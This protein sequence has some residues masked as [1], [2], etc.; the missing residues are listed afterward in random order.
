[1]KL[2]FFEN[3]IRHFLKH[4][5]NMLT[6][7]VANPI[8]LQKIYDL[9]EEA[10]SGDQKALDNLHKYNNVNVR[11]AGYQAPFITLPKPHQEKYVERSILS[12]N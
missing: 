2:A 10:R 7:T 6:V 4:K 1:M 3:I 12:K 11:V 5:G 8:E 9:C